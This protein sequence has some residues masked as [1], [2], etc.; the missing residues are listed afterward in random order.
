M[1]AQILP[2]PPRSKPRPVEKPSGT[3]FDTTE[4]RKNYYAEL[5]KLGATGDIIEEIDR[6]FER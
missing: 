4:L 6:E 3:S 5:R 2:F 1:T